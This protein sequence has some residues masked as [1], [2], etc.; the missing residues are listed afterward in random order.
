MLEYYAPCIASLAG[1]LES[2]KEYVRSQIILIAHRAL[3]SYTVTCGGHVE[4]ARPRMHGS[5]PLRD[6]SLN[7]A[8]ARFRALTFFLPDNPQILTFRNNFYDKTLFS[9]QHNTTTTSSSKWEAIPISNL[10]G[11]A[12]LLHLLSNPNGFFQLQINLLPNPS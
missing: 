6:V 5:I 2:N 4:T 8:N 3:D 10:L 9:F 7:R 11:S 12:R 1:Q